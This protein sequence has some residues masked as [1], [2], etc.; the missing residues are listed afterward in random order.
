MYFKKYS[1][2]LSLL[3]VLF[4]IQT[5]EA[6]HHK[7]NSIAQYY[8]CGD[9]CGGTPSCGPHEC[10]NVAYMCYCDCEGSTG[11]CKPTESGWL[12]NSGI[13]KADGTYAL[14]GTAGDGKNYKC[15]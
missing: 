7:I 12:W 11:K 13:K 9:D 6:C 8:S 15:T 14:N 4:L 3:V 5:N 2:L 1:L 10:G